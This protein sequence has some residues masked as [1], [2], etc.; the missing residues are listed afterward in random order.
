MPTRVGAE[1]VE[2]LGLFAVIR[3]GGITVGGAY[4][5]VFFR[6]QL[7]VA[8]RLVLA[9]A[10]L[11]PDARVQELGK[12]LGQPIRQGLGHDRAVVV[13]VPL[14]ASDQL[15]G[16]DPRGDGKG[17][18]VIE[19]AALARSH[20]VGQR[21][22]HPGLIALAVLTP[23]PVAPFLLLP[24]HVE[25]QPFAPAPRRLVE[26]DVVALARPPARNRTPPGR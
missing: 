10:P 6:D 22:Q 3:A 4:A 26:H 16:A 8:E 2:Q 23:V 13:V 12:R 5:S 18:D 15:V 19:Q 25:A 14:E 17:A 7:L 21:A 9:V 1:Q 20:E 24:E 11:A